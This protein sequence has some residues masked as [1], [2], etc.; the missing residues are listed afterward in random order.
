MTVARREA[1][2]LATSNPGKLAEFNELLRGT[3]VSLRALDRN[4]EL[5][6]ETGLSFV[7][8]ALIKARHAARVSGGP[9]MADDSGLCVIAL[10]GAPGVRSARYAGPDASDR[11]NVER[12]LGE[13]AGVAADRRQAAFHCVIVALERPDDP[14]PI[15][16]S[17][18]WPGSIAA[19]PRGSNGFGY[20]PIFLDPV[21]GVTAAELSPQ[22]K[23]AT[24]HR[25]R[26]CKELERLLGI[27]AR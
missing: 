13:L 4:A 2:L 23:N 15:I 25:S 5:P 26:A 22:Q 16:A 7:E 6:E 10:D 19:E 20:D 18:R 17:G 21:A 27:R 14:A 8:N 1:W 9:A 11:D 12:L 24:S 3:E